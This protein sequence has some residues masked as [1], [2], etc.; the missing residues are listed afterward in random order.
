MV[1]ASIFKDCRWL[2]AKCVEQFQDY[3]FSVIIHI[4]VV[5]S[6]PHIPRSGMTHHLTSIIRLRQHR[7]I[8]KV[9]KHLLHTYGHEKLLC[10][11]KE[12]NL[13]PALKKKKKLVCTFDFCFSEE[14]LI[15]CIFLLNGKQW[16]GTFATMVLLTSISGFSGYGI[17]WRYRFVQ[18]R[19]HMS[20]KKFNMIINY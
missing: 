4:P 9:V 14:T 17:L 2:E 13:G 12:S 15:Q 19:P 16:V 7:V 18:N 3:N 8:P 6:V 10:F 11:F 5:H 20:P 1:T